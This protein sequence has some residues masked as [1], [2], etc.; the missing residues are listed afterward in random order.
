LPKSP[1]SQ[2]PFPGQTHTIFDD[3]EGQT[4]W[5]T[6]SVKNL[7]PSSWARMWPSPLCLSFGLAVRDNLSPNR[8]L[9]FLI[10]PDLDLTKLFPADSGFLQSLGELLNFIHMPLPAVRIAP[11][12]IWYGLYF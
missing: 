6:V 5:L 9:A 3:Y 8:Y 1:G 2:G 12:V 10:A 4:I 7:L 11:N